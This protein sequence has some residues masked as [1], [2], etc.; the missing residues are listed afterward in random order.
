MS[1]HLDLPNFEKIPILYCPITFYF[2]EMDR[3]SFLM[4]FKIIE[5]QPYLQVS[6]VNYFQFLMENIIHVNIH[7]YATTAHAFP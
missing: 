5:F 1:I 2:L 3:I 4:K 7:M 6:L